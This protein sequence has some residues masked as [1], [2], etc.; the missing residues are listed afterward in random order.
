MEQSPTWEAASLSAVQEFP[1]ILWNR[2]HKNPPVVPY[3]E[4]DPVHTNPS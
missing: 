4:P 2:V 1:Y 3:P